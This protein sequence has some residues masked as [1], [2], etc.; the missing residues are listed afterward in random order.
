MPEYPNTLSARVPK[1]FECL[2]CLS[3]RVHKCPSS[4]QCTSAQVPFECLKCSSPL[5][6][7]VFGCL[8]VLSALSALSAKV[9]QLIN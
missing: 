7:Q 6:V 5:S 9:L 1:C 8:S 4:A 2:E 3:A